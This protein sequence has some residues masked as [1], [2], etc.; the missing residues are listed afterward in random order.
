MVLVSPRVLNV[1]SV[2]S[3]IDPYLIEFRELQ[4]GEQ[5]KSMTHNESD[6]SHRVIY[7]CCE[8]RLC[9][10]RENSPVRPRILNMMIGSELCV[11]SAWNLFTPLTQ[12]M[13]S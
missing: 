8:G 5:V 2:F 11:L 4:L 6:V 7:S 12:E 13:L 10:L 1:L 3:Q 9:L